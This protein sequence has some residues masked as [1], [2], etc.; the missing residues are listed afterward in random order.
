MAAGG[1]ER[2]EWNIADLFEA[3]VDTVPERIALVARNTRLTFAELDARANR[4]AHALADLGIGPGDHVGCYLYND[5]EHLETML[6]VY[7]LRAV[8]INVN[9]RYVD[10]ELAYLF[11]DADLAGL[12]Y[13]AEFREHAAA[14]APRIGTLRVIAEAHPDAA[15]NPPP[16]VKA[17]DGTVDFDAIVADA[18]PARDFGPRSGDDRY[19]L[20]TG[21]TT[22]SPK[23]VVWRQEDIVFAA[24]GGG[25]V[26]GPPLERPEDITRTVVENRAQRVGPF[27]PPGHP[28][29][30]QFV[31][32]G[33]GPLMHAGGQWSALGTVLGGGTCVLDPTRHL[34]LAEVCALMERERVVTVNVVGD[35]HGRPFAEF[36]EAHGHEYDLSALLLFGSGGTMLSADVKA[37]VLAALPNLLGVLEGLGSSESPVQGVAITRRD[38]D[39]TAAPSSL[40]FARRDTTVVLDDENRLVEPGSG[41][42]GRVATTGRIPLGYYNDPEKTAATFV[43]V[44]GRRYAIPGDMATVDADGSLR[45]LGRGSLCINTGGEKVYPEEVEAALKSHPS[46]LDAVVVGV[47]DPRFG[48][49]VAAVIA[50]ADGGVTLDSLQAHCRTTIA[51]YKVPRTLVVVDAVRR[52]AAGKPDYRWAKA[53]AVGE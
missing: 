12:V 20:Y 8:P 6:A 24:L 39:T 28:G 1:A 53:V 21:G 10:D 49:R 33:L 26:G 32:L 31:G 3:V 37:R 2:V 29:V 50:A 15:P 42:I 14:V 7:K 40:T 23:G 4:L 41:V 36:F 25:N 27:L 48:E 51:G 44:A 30:E 19:V 46:V 18:S 47:P 9:Y 16:G 35:A 5:A 38:G 11:D 45:L 34:D 13:G 43:E 22:G 17:A 52:S